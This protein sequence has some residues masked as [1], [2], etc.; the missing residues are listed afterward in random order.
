MQTS[1]ISPQ[2]AAQE[3][4][5]RRA[6]RRSLLQFTEEIA[7]EPSPVLHQR[8]L[9]EKLQQVCDGELSR[10]MVMMPPGSAKSTYCSVLLPAY[11]LGIHQKRRVIA[12][13]YDTGLSTLF[14]RKVR[15]LVNGP[16]YHRIFPIDV[17][18]DTRAKGEWDLSTGGGYYATGVGAAVTGR[19]G[20]LGILDDLIKGRKDADSQTVRDSTWEWYKAD[21]RTRLIPDQNAIVFIMTRWHEDDPAGRILPEGWNGESGLIE[22]RDGEIWDVLCIPAEAQPED[23]IGRKPGE[24]LWPEWFS[25]KHWMQEKISQGPRN[26]SALY[27]QRPTPDEGLFF[28]REWFW[29]FDPDDYQ[30]LNKYQTADFAVTEE[31]EADDPDYTEIGIHGVENIR[32]KDPHDPEGNE[33]DAKKLYLCLDGWSGQKAPENWVHEYFDLQKKYNPNCEFAEV[34]VIRRATEGLL[35]AQRLQRKA[36]GVI[37]W[38]PHIGDKIANARALQALAQMGLVGIADSDYGQHVLDQLI[39]FPA[40]KFDDAV[41]MSALMGRAVHEAHPMLEPK[42]EPPKDL[43]MWG[44]EKKAVSWRTQ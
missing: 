41:D 11:Y 20:H 35:E 2:E 26:W 12:G 5:T 7:I 25:P 30:R 23:P 16:D 14:G 37:E 31:A 19:R 1:P 21:F 27:Q 9:I 3:L 24:W 40:G 43:D 28:K 33:V 13:S 42:P 36:Y 18:G 39:A 10:L 38:L 44:R 15:N 4:L 8:V 34:G 17:A 32:V 6:A 29:R 22:A